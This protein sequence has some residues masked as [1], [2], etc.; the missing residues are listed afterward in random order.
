MSGPVPVSFT[1]IHAWSSITQTQITSEEA[2][3]VR[4]L[5]RDYC[6]SYHDSSNRSSPPPFAG[7]GEEDRALAAGI[8]EAV[9]RQKEKL[10]G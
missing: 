3:I 4:L 7:D 1:E 9:R 6:G 10:H 5:S 2:L 8:M